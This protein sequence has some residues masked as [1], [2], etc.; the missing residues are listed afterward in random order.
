MRTSGDFTTPIAGIEDPISCGLHVAGL[1][2]FGWQTRRLVRRAG[3]ARR[4]AAALAVFA[5]SG[6]LVLGVSAFYHVLAVDHAWKGLLQRADHAA[7]FLLI[8]GT[9]TP[10]LAIGFHGRG[11]WWMV[12]LVWGIALAALVLKMVFWSEVSDRLGLVLYIGLAAIG[13]SA[14]LV[15]PRRLPWAVILA[16]ALGGIAY[17][18]G[19]FAD[20][21]K[22]GQLLPGWFGPHEIFHLGVLAALLL[23]WRVFHH[24]SVPGRVPPREAPPPYRAEPLPSPSPGS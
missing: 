6:V 13:A 8:A 3:V 20:H 12:T 4:R 9:L 16:M 24:W 14:I 2:F 23:H 10:Y 18:A 1:L 5:C 7:I 15:L 11:R 22:V 21:L 17:A 19:A